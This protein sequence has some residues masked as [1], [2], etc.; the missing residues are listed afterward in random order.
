VAASGKRVAANAVIAG[1]FLIGLAYLGVP[2]QLGAHPRWAMKVSYIG[3][4]LGVVIYSLAWVWQS[5]WVA[6]FILFAVLAV[7]SGVGATFGKSRF[8]ASFAEDA[9]AGQLWYFGWIAVFGF[10]FALLMHLMSLR[11]E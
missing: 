2:E 4:G 11:R 1:I 9:L 7:I 8:A 6:K 10:V 5:G 3:I